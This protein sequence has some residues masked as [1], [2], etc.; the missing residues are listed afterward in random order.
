MSVRYCFNERPKVY[1]FTGAEAYD[2]MKEAAKFLRKAD[3]RGEAL[4][5]WSIYFDAEGEQWI[6]VLTTNGA[7]LAVPF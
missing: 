5:Q 3:R 1:S 4:T 6:G 2:V 7:G